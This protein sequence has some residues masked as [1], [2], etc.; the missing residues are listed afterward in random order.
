MKTKQT[1]KLTLA[2]PSFLLSHDLLLDGIKHKFNLAKVIN[3]GR[4]SQGDLYAEA[5]LCSLLLHE[6]EPE[7]PYAALSAIGNGIQSQKGWWLR[8]DPVELLV[9]AG[10]I[11]LAG[12]DHLL[13]EKSERE[14]LLTDLNIL[15]EENNLIIQAGTNQEWYLQLSEPAKISTHPIFKVIAKDIRSFLPSGPDQKWWH[16]LLTELQMVLF[17]HPVNENRQRL[18]LPMINSVWPWGEGI[19][20]KSYPLKNYTA[21][22]TDNSFVKGLLNLSEKQIPTYPSDQFSIADLEK[23]GTYLV[24]ID[25]HQYSLKSLTTL[26]RQ[27]L[28]NIRTRKI[29]ELNIYFGNGSIYHWQRPK[30]R[31]F[32]FR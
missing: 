14:H 30:F 17:V 18:S 4:H 5:M 16:T 1:L 28:E 22:W 6:I 23:Y 27:L 21:I 29:H 19:I 9:D 24:T 3:A 32:D 7:I 2:L 15:L 11:C 10:N 26:V 12:R 31:L 20:T 13:L 25:Y 8:I